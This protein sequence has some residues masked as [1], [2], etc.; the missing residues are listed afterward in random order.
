MTN[1]RTLTL[2]VF[3]S[4]RS[5]G[6]L[7]MD[8]CPSKLL[9]PALQD[10]MLSN[11]APEAQRLERGEFSHPIPGGHAQSRRCSNHEMMNGEATVDDS[12]KV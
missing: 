1:A 4:Q 8:E 7:K 6:Q 2:H 11:Q 9:K 12:V 10:I 3:V 5:D